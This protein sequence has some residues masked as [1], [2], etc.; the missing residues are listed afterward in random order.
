MDNQ[1]NYCNING[2]PPPPLPH[3]NVAAA[4][5]AVGVIAPIAANPPVGFQVGEL[6]YT[7]KIRI[8]QNYHPRHISWHVGDGDLHLAD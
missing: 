6:H 8:G 1:P 4:N 3:E 2:S 7:I 5:S